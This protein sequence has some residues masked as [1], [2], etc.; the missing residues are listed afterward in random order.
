M[1]SNGP[2]PLGE[3]NIDTDKC[4]VNNGQKQNSHASAQVSVHNRACCHRCPKCD[5]M[6]TTNVGRVETRPLSP[7]SV[8]S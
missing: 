2:L 3:T 4:N 6:T 7:H 8:Y 1:L 5:L